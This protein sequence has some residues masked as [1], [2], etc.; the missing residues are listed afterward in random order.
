R[1]PKLVTQG[2]RRSEQM[3]QGQPDA[4]DFRIPGGERIPEAPRAFHVRDSVPVKI[5]EAAGI[6]E[7]KRRE[8]RRENDGESHGGRLRRQRK[9]GARAEPPPIGGTSIRLAGAWRAPGFH[10]GRL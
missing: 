6:E 10:R 9:R 5:G 4:A 7:V 3:E 8:R 1:S 2:E